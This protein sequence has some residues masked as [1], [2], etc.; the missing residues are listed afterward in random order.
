VSPDYYPLFLTAL[1]AGLRRGELV[2]LEFGDIQFGNNDE[3]PNRYILVRHNYV[4]REFTTPKSKKSRRVDLSRQLR[5][6]LLEVRARRMLTA[7]AKGETSILD[8]LVFPSP[9]GRC[10]TLTTWSSGTSCLRSSARASGDSDFMIC[11]THSAAC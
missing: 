1:R 7:F 8:E 3:D 11:G 2:A 9:E 10:W 5:S 6:E 4:N